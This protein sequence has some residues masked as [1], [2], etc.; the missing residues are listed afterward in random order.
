[1]L[2]GAFASAPRRRIQHERE[3]TG[4][5]GSAVRATASASLSS[6]T[7]GIA[8]APSSKSLH[9]DDA[10]AASHGAIATQNAQPAAAGS[11]KRRREDNQQPHCP[12]LAEQT[13]SQAQAAAWTNLPRSDFAD[14]PQTVR[15]PGDMLERT[16]MAAFFQGRLACSD[17]GGASW[18]DVDD[19][20]PTLYMACGWCHNVVRLS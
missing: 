2:A 11:L 1:L 16:P 6:T 18:Q 19:F 17:C 5:L 10:S 14:P 8:C 12:T 13:Q 3:S 20:D 15:R 4:A 9:N 7:R